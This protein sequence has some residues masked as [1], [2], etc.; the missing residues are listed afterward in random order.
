M[1]AR[2]MPAPTRRLNI[3]TLAPEGGSRRLNPLVFPRHSPIAIAGKRLES[4]GVENTEDNRRDWRQLLYT[5]P[6]A[7]RRRPRPGRSRHL[8]RRL[9]RTAMT[10]ASCCVLRC[11]Y[12]CAARRVHACA[13][14]RCRLLLPRPRAACCALPG[15]GA[16]LAGLGQY[17]SGAIM[18]EETL[19]Q[20]GRDG[21]D[22]QGAAGASLAACTA[23]SVACAAP[24]SAP[25]PARQGMARP[26]A[27]AHAAARCL[28]PPPAGRTLQRCQAAS[29]TSPH[30]APFW[31]GHAGTLPHMLLAFASPQAPSLWMC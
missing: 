15:P 4:V 1:P 10:R 12:A 27:A 13:P 6:G 23:Q 29:P 21:E 22:L 30:G 3:G 2:R 19:Y 11:R 7:P 25:L 14:A 16:L 24:H 18:F 28:V 8:P 20:K 5:A 17:I 31:L 9:R 26:A